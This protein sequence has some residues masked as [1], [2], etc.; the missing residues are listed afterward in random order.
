MKEKALWVLLVLIAISSL[1]VEL[2]S[3]TLKV[4]LS[5]DTSLFKFLTSKRASSF[6]T[7]VNYLQ[8]H[9]LSKIERLKAM[10]IKEEFEEWPTTIDANIRYQLV[11]GGRYNVHKGVYACRD[12]I[13][14]KPLRNRVELPS[15]N[16]F[17]FYTFIQTNL[18]ILVMGDSLAVEFGIWFQNAG[19]AKNTTIIEG[20]RWRHRIAEGLAFSEVDG[21]G[22]ISIWR[23][24][25]FWLRRNHGLPLPNSG[26]GWNKTWVATLHS[27]LPTSS[28]KVHVLI[29]RVSYPW[30]S[31]NNVTEE[32]LSETLSVAQEYLGEPLTII[33][34]TVPINNNIVTRQDFDDFRAMNNRIRSFVTN[35]HSSDVLVSDLEV[36][37]DNIIEWNAKQIGM[38]TSYPRCFLEERLAMR[39]NAHHVAQVCGERVPINSTSCRRNMLLNDGLHFCTE[40]LGPRLFANW[41]CLLEC[42]ER[43][44]QA[45][46]ECERGCNEIYFTLD[47][48]LSAGGI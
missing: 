9:D 37:M 30:L 45:I 34:M 7:N 15:S 36:Y 32:S 6:P 13:S 20:L 31:M 35:L 47:D 39:S 28:D 12:K 16:P 2:S 43:S 14:G 18:N 1:K 29:F 8:I 40:T 38:N 24:I 4:E 33:F 27:R 5:S 22:T 41:A 26:R 46:R 10:V 11:R 17:D 3:D 25:D 21:G 19:R 44:S 48:T 42:I 23:N